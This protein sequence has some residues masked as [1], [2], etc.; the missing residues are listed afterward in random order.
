MHMCGDQ[1]PAPPVFILLFLSELSESLK[2]A[3][4]VFQQRIHK[5]LS[6]YRFMVI[7]LFIPG[8]SP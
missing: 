6:E 5:T 4:V 2:H 1:S 8:L 3:T 7:G